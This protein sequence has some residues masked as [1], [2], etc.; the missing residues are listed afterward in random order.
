MAHKKEHNQISLDQLQRDDTTQGKTSIDELLAQLHSAQEKITHL[1]KQMEQNTVRQIDLMH[2]SVNAI[3]ENEPTKLHAALDYLP[4]GLIILGSDGKIEKANPAARTLLTLNN[5]AS[6]NLIEQAMDSFGVRDMITNNL[7]SQQNMQGDFKF[8]SKNDKILL[9]RWQATSD[10][11]GQLLG[12]VIII[13][14]MTEIL[15][16]RKAKS[17]FI[18]AISHELRTP[19]TSIQ[20]A[21]SNILA[22]VTGKI[23]NKTKEYLDTVIS[24]CHRY[25]NLI[26]DLLDTSKLETG[27]MPLN[28]TAAKIESIANKAFDAF[29][30]IADDKGV[31][32]ITQ[33]DRISTPVL[34]DPQRI[35]QVIANLLDNAIKHTPEHGIVTLSTQETHDSIIISVSDTGAG[36][37]EDIQNSIFEK[38]YQHHRQAGPGYRGA[39][40]GLTICKEIMKAHGGSIWLEN[41]QKIGST[42][43]CSIPK[44]SP[45]IILNNHLAQLSDS[46]GSAKNNITLVMLKLQHPQQ[47]SEQFEQQAKNIIDDLFEELSPILSD[48]KDLALIIDNF[49]MALIIWNDKSRRTKTITGKI[50]KNISNISS[51]KFGQHQLLPMMAVAKYPDDKDST[52]KLISA[53]R[54]KY[55][56]MN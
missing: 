51:I 8:K 23:N 32:L 36:I 55:E 28:R 31:N 17:D 20:N 1:E 13:T 10:R 26:S 3:I 56:K 50:K 19:L 2:E 15:A 37:P 45:E 44:A 14:D 53:A 43:K 40:L 35:E 5:Q 52:T 16:N 54:Q 4:E 39:G 25:G 42:F 27:S 47:E 38:F 30:S 7:K 6:I 33:F 29:K 22:G 18:A 46:V 12:A 11:N 34:A 9:M 41:E 49:E 24:D 21:V 48:E